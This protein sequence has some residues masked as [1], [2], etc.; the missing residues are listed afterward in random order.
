M[1]YGLSNV[2]NANAMASFYHRAGMA[3]TK[4]GVGFQN[5]A[6]ATAAA[7]RTSQVNRDLADI[8]TVDVKAAGAEAADMSLEEYK[9][10]IWKKISDLPM[11]ASSR[12]ESISIQ[13]TDDGFEAMKN[14]PEYEAWVLDTLAQNFSFQNPWTAVCGGG[15]A[16]HRFGTTKEQYHGES[17]YPGYMG[18]QGAALFEKKSKGGFWEQRMERQKEYMELAH[19]AAAK[20][21]M[22]M[23][24]RMNGGTISAAELLMG[25]I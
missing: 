11:S 1:D 4:N 3:V 14:D 13:I 25:L 12:M 19:K 16:I 20:R 9:Q 15:Y 18:G 6:S 10:Y 17:W 8:Q 2:F 5:L 21:K 7:V 23:K 24:L 22:M